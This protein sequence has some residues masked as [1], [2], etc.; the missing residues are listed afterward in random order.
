MGVLRLR[1]NSGWVA[2]VAVL[3]IVVQ[4][5]AIDTVSLESVE[6]RMDAKCKL[7][8]RTKRECR[9]LKKGAV[10]ATLREGAPELPLCLNATNPT[11]LPSACTARTYDAAEVS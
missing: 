2:V 5:Y 6:L 8:G 9:K 4:A 11:A 1:C 10:A 7:L 3:A